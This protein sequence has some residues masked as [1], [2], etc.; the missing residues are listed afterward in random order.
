MLLPSTTPA[1]MRDAIVGSMRTLRAQAG[2][3][4]PISLG[5]QT[6]ALSPSGGPPPSE[7]AESMSIAKQIGAIGVAFYAWSGTTAAQWDTIARQR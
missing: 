3:A 7:I 6:V 2:R 1:Q 4:M 5:G